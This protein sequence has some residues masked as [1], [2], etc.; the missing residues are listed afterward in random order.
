MSN[1]NKQ[2]LI[3]KELEK[4]TEL[5]F[6]IKEFS[7]VKLVNGNHSVL[8]EIEQQN[9]IL[10]LIDR[11]W[12]MEAQKIQCLTDLYLDAKKP[13]EKTL[14]E[15]LKITTSFTTLFSRLAEKRGTISSLRYIYDQLFCYIE[16]EEEYNTQTAILEKL[17]KI[18]DKKE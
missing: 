1:N 3:K 10:K 7:N 16:A 18:P 4:F 14:E 2:E 8:D 12:S 6:L 11:D 5:L 15:L 9:E 13:K 17:N